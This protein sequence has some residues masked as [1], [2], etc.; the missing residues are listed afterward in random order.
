LCEVTT[1]GDYE[2]VYGEYQQTKNVRQCIFT[3]DTNFVGGCGRFF[4]GQPHE[5]TAAMQKAMQ[6]KEALMFCGHE[7]S[8]Q[9]MEFCAKVDPDN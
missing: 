5:M 4:E 9:N 8:I 7:Y 6:Y 2:I 3:G 1:H